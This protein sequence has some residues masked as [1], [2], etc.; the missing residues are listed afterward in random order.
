PAQR[1][2]YSRLKSD[3]SQYMSDFY[4]PT[5][6]FTKLKNAATAA[7]RINL[8]TGKWGK[9]IMD[10][11]PRYGHR[12]TTVQAIRT[13]NRQIENL[14]GSVPKPPE[15]VSKPSVPALP[16]LPDKP[17][18]IEPE[19]PPEPDIKPFDPVATRRRILQG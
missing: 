3:W 12:P 5:G 16:H 11:S 7:D 15:V 8:L 13:L 10:A 18:P 14:P 1:P 2:V 4:D 19:L 6:P 9:E 17:Q